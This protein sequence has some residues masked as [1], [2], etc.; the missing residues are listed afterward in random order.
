MS[1][2]YLKPKN[3]TTSPVIIGKVVAVNIATQTCDVQPSDGGAILLD[4]RLKAIE[5]EEEEGIIIF[6]KVDS[7]VSVLCI[8]NT[9]DAI[10]IAYSSFSSCKIVIKN[11]LKIEIS[12]SG[13]IIVNDG[14]N[15]GIIKVQA[16]QNE[17]EKLNTY[18][19]KITTVFTQW[20]PTLPDGI[21][22][23]TQ[24]QLLVSPLPL[25]NLGAITNDKIKH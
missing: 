7:I 24:M 15:G 18:V 19:S 14:V 16:L 21:A 10:V 4:C 2:P 25:A 5:D 9:S 20:I 8:N 12:D 1:F 23:K 22:L 17:I 11:V 13:D 6:P 3:R